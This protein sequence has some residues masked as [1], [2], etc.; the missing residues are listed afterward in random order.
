MLNGNTGRPEADETGLKYKDTGQNYQDGQKYQ[1]A[2]PVISSV[3]TCMRSIRPR[4]E[5]QTKRI[6][7][8][9]KMLLMT[10]FIAS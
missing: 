2:V 4:K 5:G 1:L 8:K 9:N 3:H 7:E 10:C 6:K